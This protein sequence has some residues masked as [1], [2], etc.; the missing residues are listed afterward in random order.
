MLN[1]YGPDGKIQFDKDHQAAREY[2]LQ[3]VNQNTVFF[4]D[5]EEK[6]DY[7]ITE[8]YYEREV[9]DKY[10][11]AFVKDLFKSA[12]AVKF[13]FP[14]FMGAFKYYTGYT[15][16]T[17]DG[18]RYLE[19]FE[20]RVCMTAL[21]LADGDQDF[22]VHLMHEIIS[23]RFQP[24]TPTF[25]NAG[26]KQR[27]ELV[28][29]FEGSALVT[30]S[31]GE[32]PIS[33]VSVG[34]EVL[35]HDG[36]FH[37][38]TE[39]MRRKSK[40]ALVTLNITGNSRSLT[41]TVEH[42][43][44]VLPGNNS[45]Q[46]ADVLKGDGSTESL[47]WR[48][49]KDVMPGDYVVASAPEHNVQHKDISVAA[50]L[51][52]LENGW[53]ETIVE[54]NGRV[55]FPTR[56]VRNNRRKS[57][58]ESV[59]SHAIKGTLALDADFGRLVGY[60][61]S[62]GYV[63][64]TNGSIK[65]V[66]FT[67]NSNDTEAIDDAA[68]LVT[69]ILGVTPVLRVNS[70]GSTNVSVWSGI[71]GELFIRLFGTGHDKKSL[72]LLIHSPKECLYGALAGVFRGD[73]HTV[74]QGM[75]L[76]LVN[77]PLIREIRN[78]ALM[79]GLIP[80][81]RVY[82]NQAGNPTGQIG[83][84]N[85]S[86][87]NIDFI[88]YVGKNLHKFT[89]REV[90]AQAKMKRVDGHAVYRVRETWTR[91]NTGEVYNLHVEGTHT[92]TVEGFTVHNCFLLRMEDNM[93]SIA[94]GINSSLQLSKRGGGVALL[95]SNL[96][97]HGAPIKQI[98]NQS[99]GV[100]PVMKLLE[101]SFSYANQ[102]GARQGAGAVYLNAHH[103]DI[104][105]FLDTKRENADEKV[106]IKTL[107]LGVVIPDITF[108]LAR[109]NED[110]YLFSPYDVE[111]VY[112]M[113]FADIYVTEKYRE[114]VDDP[115]IRKTKISARNFFQTLAELQFESGYPYVMYEDTVN[116]ANPI[117][118]KITHSN[119]CVSGDTEILTDKGYRRVRDLHGT[120][121][122]FNV[123][124]DARARDFD[125]GSKG[126]SVESS[127]KMFKTAENADVYRVTT[128]E[129]HEL[130]CTEWHKFYVDRD[131]ELVKIPLAEIVPGDRLL[132]QGG[133]NTSWGDVHEPDLAY[134]AGVLAADGTFTNNEGSPI[135]GVRLDLYG[136]KAQ[137]VDVVRDT[138]HR[139]L[140]GREDLCERQSTTTPEFNYS[141]QRDAHSLS[142]TPL[143][144]LLAEHGVTKDTKVSVPEFVKRG[145]RETQRAFIN[146]VWQ[147]DG[148]I[149]GNVKVG[150]ISIELGST[151]ETFLQDMQKLL[152]GF[153]VYTR[154]YINRKHDGTAMLPDGRGGRREYRQRRTWTLRAMD[155]SSR[156]ALHDLVEWRDATESY[157]QI[158]CAS[159]KSNTYYNTH[160]FRATV[161]G[162]E[163]MGTEDVYDVTV[164]N[165]NSIVV[166]AIVT[167]Q[168]SEILQISTPSTYLDDL[169]YDEV[170]NDIS[171]NLGS[172]NIAKAMDG[173]DLAE[174]VEAAIRALTAVSDMTSI[175]SVPSIRKANAE[176]HAIGLG[177]MNLHGYLARERVHYGSPE[178][179]DFTNMYFYTVAYHCVRASNL[180]AKE[181][182]KAFVGFEDSKYASG[183]YFDK[184][185]DQV[186]EPKTSRVRELF[187]AAGIHIPTQEDWRALK[188]SVREHGIYNMYL[189]AVA[190][191]GSISYVNN[192]T[193]SIHPIVSQI[194]IRKEGKVGRVYYPAAYLTND[195]REFYR[196]AYEIGPEAIIDTYAEATQHVD[197]GLSLTL[198]FRDTATTRDV[199]K[200]QI[201]AW[202]K[203]IKTLYYIRVRQMALEGTEIENCVSCQL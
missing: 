98:E 95:L 45:I 76:D 177:Q 56:D 109:N 22:A 119:L 78:A 143:G 100:V 142:S 134:L 200:A 40:D 199:N 128:L 77:V 19:R 130:T 167:G 194:E 53:G 36:G 2:F 16:K 165:G 97:E 3:H 173:G 61:L 87:E 89:R 160:R 62:E 29:C 66:R 155:R 182:G 146:G 24:A 164:E 131:G 5:L 117:K 169:S 107:S 55:L 171:C 147:M 105:A 175:D 148:C 83:L 157:W 151:E 28:S 145:D 122:D 153:G 124:V 23:G 125:L 21:F 106:R 168:C 152:L 149:T 181:R 115:R 64:I 116:R 180:I 7:L 63:H 74:A 114:M 52:G 73:G 158:R 188:E 30:T 43:V 80:R 161:A 172:L 58:D 179:L 57:T 72:G 133:E 32:V 17:F 140:A 11:F 37:T 201:Y 13:R 34:D 120:Q 69:K 96:R 138:V 91:K 195:N 196:D 20:D 174:T 144:K 88:I 135:P 59:Q 154:R 85:V 137:F 67:F 118:G 166:N 31:Q 6:L 127:T 26:K 44:L 178:G 1:L 71:V 90:N 47:K 186:W 189:Q 159:I 111:R 70:D 198:F 27:G 50:V 156:E 4:H 33:E 25:L 92:Y 39:V 162:I 10:P 192:S 46:A 176:G 136:D 110:M 104:M 68:D 102:L 103:P 54:R 60:Y 12:Y 93:E 190:P 41:A 81:D 187:D 112:G 65:G 139:V 99:S 141:A 101:D 49:I 123:I 14:T 82:I 8:N 108:E 197:Q 79:V 18:K 170:G 86:Q 203:G 150:N 184:Y 15:L 51:H 202:R 84:S 183:E 129:G 163:Y 9:L 193:S 48:A 191:T 113:P 75:V 121:E 38:V 185:T 132:V 42:P 94:R 126:M 35:S